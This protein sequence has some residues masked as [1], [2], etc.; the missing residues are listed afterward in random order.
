MLD[1]VFRNKTNQKISQVIDGKHR[2]FFSITIDGC[3]Y[4]DSLK[5]FKGSVEGLSIVLGIDGKSE[6]PNFNRVFEYDYQPT[7]KEIKYCLQDSRIVAEFIDKEFEAG[8]IRLTMSS[9]AFDRIKKAIKNFDTLFPM[10]EKEEDD[11]A[12]RSYK[13]GFCYLNPD[14][15]GID[16]KDVYV[17]DVNSLFPYVMA[18][19]PLPFGLGFRQEPRNEEQLYIVDFFC[20][21]ELKDG[22]I[23]MMQIKNN[24]SY[25]NKES[26]YLNESLGITR[27]TLTNID[28]KLFKE[29]YNVYNEYG[30]EYLTFNSKIGVLADIILENNRIKEQ[31]SK[32]GDGYTREQMKYNNNMT[33]GAFGINPQRYNG[34]PYLKEEKDRISLRIEEEY[35]KG[36]Y[37]PF[38]SFV[39]SW[40]RY[41]TITNAQKNY[42]SF[43]YSDT[44]SIHLLNPAKGLKLDDKELGKW[45]QEGWHPKDNW[46]WTNNT[47]QY[48]YFP[49]AKYLRQKAYV[50]A[51]EN[52]TIFQG[53]NQYNDYVTELKCAGMPDIVKQDIEWNDF[54]LGSKFEGKLMKTIVAGGVCLK[55]TTYSIEG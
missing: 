24:I 38:A 4:R 6:K 22:Y 1:Y 7:D 54:Y 45:K 43:I 37:V 12:R 2:V 11:F 40:S 33:Y 35:G 31:A 13:G 10:L 25:H 51:D 5:K 3:E 15:K 36:R 39:T 26:E 42:K 52:F 19:M 50:H 34:I 32:D 17:Y 20:E 47:N 8:R 49:N 28:Y 29:H 48:N 14:L 16:L 23:P 27:L 18:Y 55:P 53:R 41:I 44:D 30:H 9:E 46:N 21:F